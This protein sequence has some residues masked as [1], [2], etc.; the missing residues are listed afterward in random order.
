[1]ISVPEHQSVVNSLKEQLLAELEGEIRS[2]VLFGSVARGETTED[3]DID[4]LIIT[5]APL[6][7]MQ[8]IDKI[9]YHIDL[10][11]GVFTQLVFFTTQGFEKE[12]ITYRSYFSSDVI[13]QGIV[14]YDDGTF[15]RICEK[16]ASTVTGVPGGQ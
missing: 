7:T 11:N 5:D 8:R 6:E 3:S 9:S 12:T 13:S 14:L 1:M 16:A 4:I 15:R 10:E 2:I